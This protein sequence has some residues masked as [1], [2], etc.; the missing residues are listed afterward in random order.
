MATHYPGCEFAVEPV[1]CSP[2]GHNHYAYSGVQEVDGKVVVVAA[3][4]SSVP[5]GVFSRAGLD[6]N[7][8][9]PRNVGVYLHLRAPHLGE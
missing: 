9:A 2:F 4:V 7:A 6:A 8:E 3:V 5:Q 1:S